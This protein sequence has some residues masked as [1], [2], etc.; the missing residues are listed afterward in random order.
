MIYLYPSL[1]GVVLDVDQSF[2]W[3]RRHV[4]VVFHHLSQHPANILIINI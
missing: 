1:H 3:Q 2:P 4:V